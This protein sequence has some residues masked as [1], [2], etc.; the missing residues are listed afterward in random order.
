MDE[1]QV[2]SKISCTELTIVKKLTIQEFFLHGLAYMVDHANRN[3]SSHVQKD[4][5]TASSGYCVVR[6]TDPVACGA[7]GSILAFA[8]DDPGSGKIIQIAL[9][10]VDG[11]KIWANTWYDIDWK[12]RKGA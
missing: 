8:K 10:Y 3:W 4:R 2:D 5:G 1:D 11:R 7:K 12:E 6:G 9:T